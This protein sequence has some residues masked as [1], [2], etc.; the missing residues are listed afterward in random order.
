MLNEEH[1]ATVVANTGLDNEHSGR[2]VAGEE[3]VF[4]FS[5]ENVLA[6]GRYSPMLTLAQRGTGL[7]VIDRFDSAFTFV[8][9]ASRPLGGLVDLPVDVAVDRVTDRVPEES[10]A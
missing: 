4:S 10:P 6:P 9:T 5:F 2:F 8:V 7:D 1:K 3:A